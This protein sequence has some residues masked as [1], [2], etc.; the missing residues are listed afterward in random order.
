MGEVPGKVSMKKKGK[1][2]QKGGGNDGLYSNQRVADG[3]CFFAPL[4]VPLRSEEVG[5]RDMWSV[6]HF[7]WW[8]LQLAV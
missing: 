8:R 4:F 7:P 3:L 5:E 2:K 6:P 1:D